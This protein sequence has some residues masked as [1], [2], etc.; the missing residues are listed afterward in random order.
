MKRKN[1]RTT[2]GDLLGTG[3]TACLVPVDALLLLSDMEE[4]LRAGYLG[5]LL[6]GEEEGQKQ[7]NI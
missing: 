1:L 3:A 5:K 6:D 4:Y 2:S 7:G